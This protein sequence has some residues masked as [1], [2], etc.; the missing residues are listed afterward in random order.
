[1]N[2]SVKDTEAL[3]YEKSSLADIEMRVRCNLLRSIIGIV[4]V[5]SGVCNASVT[6]VWHRS[7]RRV[8]FQ[9]ILIDCARFDSFEPFAILTEYLSGLNQV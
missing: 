6:R 8:S 4:S 2:E 7:L 1:M 9:T 5:L 3:D